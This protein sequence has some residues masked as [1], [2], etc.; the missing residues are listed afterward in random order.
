MNIDLHVH[1]KPHSRCCSTTAGEMV[2]TAK[3][4]GLDALVFTNHHRYMEPEEISALNREFSPFRVY[5][6]IEVTVE[7]DEDFI[8]IGLTEAQLGPVEWKSLKYMQLY[9]IVRRFGGFIAMAHPYRYSEEIA[10]GI[11]TR[12]PD[13]ME[14]H[15]TNIVKCDHENVRLL[16]ERTGCLQLCN[17]DAHVLYELGV[18]YNEIP[19]LPDDEAGLARLLRSGAATG[20][21][22][23]DRLGAYNTQVSMR[24]EHIRRMLADGRGS[25]YFTVNTGEPAHFF[26]QVM[27]GKTYEI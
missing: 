23:A 1:S 4:I 17:S 8:V 5:N 20:K 15:S 19:S 27:A 14:I 22:M 12:K 3:Y 10:S 18:Y 9:D 7:E 25:D 26:E 21:S 13:G 16:A 6:G 2:R 11:G 24:E